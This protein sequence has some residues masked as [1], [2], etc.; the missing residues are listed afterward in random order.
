MT[1]LLQHQ[2]IM[3]FL[4]AVGFAAAVFFGV[5]LRRNEARTEQRLRVVSK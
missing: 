1:E 3:Y 5:M 4:S 2:G